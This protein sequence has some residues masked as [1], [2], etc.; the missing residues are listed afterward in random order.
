MS[1]RLLWLG[2]LGFC[3]L[4]LVQA[5]W[6]QPR[7][8]TKFFLQKARSAWGIPDYQLW[9]SA[10]K[11]A[12]RLYQAEKEKLPVE[13]KNNLQLWLSFLWAKYYQYQGLPPAIREVSDFKSKEELDSYIALLETKIKNLGKAA[14]YFSDYNKM[15]L[16]LSVKNNLRNRIELEASRRLEGDLKNTKNTLLVYRAFLSSESMRWKANSKPPQ[17][18]GDVAKQ[19]ALIQKIQKN[20]QKLMRKQKKLAR[21]VQV[22][23]QGYL[24]Y[25]K[26]LVSQQARSRGFVIA[27]SIAAVVGV[28][29]MIGFLVH[30]GYIFSDDYQKVLNVM[31]QKGELGG[32]SVTDY[33]EWQGNLF[34]GSAIGAGAVGGTGVVLLLTG[35]LTYPSLKDRE[36]AVLKSH[37][38]YLKPPPKSSF[39]FRKHFRRKMA[40]TL[41]PRVG[42]ASFQNQTQT[43]GVW[44]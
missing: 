43:L 20:Q 39:L 36:Q 41:P 35:A 9:Y 1:K 15:F 6:A 3:C 27:G 23:H 37:G 5:A 32:L 13:E 33:R 38:Q 12:Q 42:Q 24:E 40:R 31:H 17:P 19:K 11:D 18:S 10:M 25:R 16:Q 4:F 29:V 21:M 22:A 8:N 2:W 30:R 28:G 26:R 7:Q 14:D 34:L 44:R